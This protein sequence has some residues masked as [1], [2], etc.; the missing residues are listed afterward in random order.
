[1]PDPAIEQ[2]L[3]TAGPAGVAVTARSPG[4]LDEWQPEAE[5]L[6][7]GFGAPVEP[8]SQPAVFAQPIDRSFVAVVQVI[9]PNP[10]DVRCHLLVGIVMLSITIPSAKADT[11]TVWHEETYMVHHEAEGHWEYYWAEYYE[12]CFWVED[13]P[14]WDDKTMCSAQPIRASSAP[15]P[16][17]RS[18]P[19]A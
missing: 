13:S 16:N 5:R 3:A 12:E 15:M 11:C 14:A 10:P 17:L 18:P 19:P 9:A 7:L 1:M 8:F 2:A 6:C 4:F